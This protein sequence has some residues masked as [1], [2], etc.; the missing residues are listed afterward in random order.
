MT[1]RSIGRPPFFTNAVVRNMKHEQT[2][3]THS[4][5][6]L[7]LGTLIEEVQVKA[8]SLLRDQWCARFA[9]HE[10]RQQSTWHAFLPDIVGMELSDRDC[11]NADC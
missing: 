10:D 11:G 8:R 4:M 7:G 3:I 2:T 5:H 6:L 9:P 1:V